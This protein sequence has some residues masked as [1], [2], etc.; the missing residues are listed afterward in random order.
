MQCFEI[1]HQ[2]GMHIWDV[3]A[4]IAT[5]LLVV[6]MAAHYYNQ[7]K[8]KEAFEKELDQKIRE[9]REDTEATMKEA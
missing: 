3:P 1:I 9:I 7:K 4:W 5:I 2:M 8:R 6:M